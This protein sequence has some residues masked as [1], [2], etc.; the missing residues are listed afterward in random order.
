MHWRTLRRG[1]QSGETR[2]NAVD[3]GLLSRW[4]K[5]DVPHPYIYVQ[6]LILVSRE[7]LTNL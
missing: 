4:Q 2:G 7:W 1:L 3:P 6:A 5:G